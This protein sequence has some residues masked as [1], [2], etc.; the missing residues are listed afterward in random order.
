MNWMWQLL[1][2]ELWEKP[3]GGR[4]WF[5]FTPELEPSVIK[6]RADFRSDLTREGYA[7]VA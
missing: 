3:D 4:V 2:W 5:K 6:A 7:K 1:G